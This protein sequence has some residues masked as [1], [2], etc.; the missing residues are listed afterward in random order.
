MQLRLVLATVVLSCAAEAPNRAP[1]IDPIAPI[2]AQVGETIELVVPARDP[3]G[4]RL[5]VAVNPVPLTAELV[6]DGPN[7]RFVWAPLIS[8]T[9]PSGKVHQLTFSADDGR[10]GLATRQLNVTVLPQSGAPEFLGPE[11]YVLN[12]SVDDDLSFLVVVKDDD[13]KEV[14][15]T[16]TSDP[17]P[18]ARFTQ[19][20]GKSASFYWK[21]SELQAKEREY[22]QLVVEA[23]DGVHP[24]VVREIS[25]LLM[26]ADEQKNCAGTPPTFEPC[27]EPSCLPVGDLDG[28][29]ALA[30]RLYATDVES[31][32]REL[33]L[34]YATNNPL[35]AS[36]YDGNTVALD[37]CSPDSDP[38]CP[39]NP[40]NRYFIGIL[41]SP[42]V[43]A[44]EPLLLHYYVTAVDD[45]DVKSTSCDHTTRFPKVG[46]HTV[47]LYPKQWTGTCKDDAYESTGLEDAPVIPVRSEIDSGVT[48]DLRFC[49]DDGEDLYRVDAPPGATVTVQVIHERRHGALEVTLLDELGAVVPALT[50]AGDR[51]AARVLGPVYAQVVAPPGEKSGD[52]SYAV[53]A[54]RAVGDCPNDASEPNDG[55]DEA[56]FVQRSVPRDVTICAAD[57]DSVLVSAGDDESI[58]VGLAFQHAFGDLDMVLRAPSGEVVAHSS[59]AENDERIVWHVDD[60]GSYVVT[61][62]G[63]HGAA[64][65]GRLTIDVV[66]TA[67]MCFEDQFTPNANAKA[68]R[69]LPENTYT[70]L[71]VCPNAEDWFRIDLNEGERLTVQAA[72]YQPKD[73]PLDLQIFDDPAGLHIAGEAVASNSPQT[74][75]WGVTAASEGSFRFRVRNNGPYTAIYDLAFWVADA[76]GPGQ[77]LDDRFSPLDTADNALEVDHSLG[78]LTRLKVCPG[79]EDWFKL[80]AAAYEELYVYVFGFSDEAPLIAELY[81]KNTGS[82]QKIADGIPGSN[83]VE[84]RFLPEENLEVFLRVLGAPGQ[85]HHYDLVFGLD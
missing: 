80:S 37:Q 83:G 2:T 14:A 50:N 60:A 66:E 53:V 18:G 58:V 63:Y 78:F 38:G 29:G 3:D 43:N 76:G 55:V 11:G 81:T 70:D 8:D 26:N 21:P 7:T 24:K 73:A 30:F 40:K 68:A 4:D 31:R 27:D 59:S 64:N 51:V 32:I 74:R 61:V 75:Q 77:C 42:A 62:L 17:I 72:A 54:T 19:L 85:I 71:L 5:S 47:A 22:Y 65:T 16:A 49:V 34:H 57:H 9:G 28:S 20:D 48:Y 41:A 79:G 13:T 6:P 52:Q 25:L 69:L 84:V 36:S 46:H 33:T 10:G 56:I 67:T 45:D 12:L 44:T 1:V 82:L 35:D 39:S 23:D 15:I